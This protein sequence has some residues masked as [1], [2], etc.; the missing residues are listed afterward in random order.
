MK[1]WPGRRGFYSGEL[2]R[3]IAQTGSIRDLKEI[4]KD[5]RRLFV[6]AH[7]ITPQWHVRIQAAFQKYTDNAVSKTVNFPA[8]AAPEDVRQ[9]YL[10]AYE[11]GLK[12]IT[13]YRDRSRDQQVLSF[14]ADKAKEKFP[15]SP[16]GPAPP[17][18]WGSPN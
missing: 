5:V 17:A 14:G 10:L 11:L 1:M 12:G 13:I 18:P 4:P 16:P 3:R 9:V 2:M 6:T 8:S 15:P 7:D